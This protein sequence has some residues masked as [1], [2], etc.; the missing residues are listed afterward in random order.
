MPSRLRA[1]AG[2]AISFAAQNKGKIAL[3]L[4]AIALGGAAYGASK[5][6][7]GRKSK[8]QTLSKIRT[9]RRIMQEKVK[10]ERAKKSYEKVIS[11]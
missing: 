1:A 8:R 10:L 4:G 5:F 3:G 9:K 2:K 11:Q 6:F 7:R